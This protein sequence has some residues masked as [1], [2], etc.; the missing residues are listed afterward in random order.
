[1][2]QFLIG[3]FKAI[4][5]TIYDMVIFVLYMTVFLYLVSQGVPVVNVFILLF[6]AFL[7]PNVITDD[8]REFLKTKGVEI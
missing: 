5:E 4:P 8:E 7:G 3:T 1:M 2:K 6:F